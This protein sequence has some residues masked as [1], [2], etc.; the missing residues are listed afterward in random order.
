MK[1]AAVRRGERGVVGA[2]A[3]AGKGAV[4]ILWQITAIAEIW[5]SHQMSLSYA[6]G[7]C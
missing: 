2:R 7:R 4:K 5:K 6:M 1:L 3:G